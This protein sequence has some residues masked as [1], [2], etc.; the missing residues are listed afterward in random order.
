MTDEHT[1]MKVSLNT[2]LRGV[3][4]ACL[5]HVAQA[6]AVEATWSGYATLGYSVSDSNYTYQRFINKDGSFKADSLVAGQVDLRLS[7]EWSATLQAKLAPAD[8]SDSGY[9]ASAAWAFLAW[10]PSNDWLVRAGKLRI[11]LYLNSES[12]DVG[13]SHDMARLP[14]EMYFISPTNDLTGL[15]VS[16]SFALGEQDISLDAYSGNAK[17]VARLWR[18]DGLPPYVQAGADFRKVEVNLTGLVL[19][20]RS[21]ALTWRVGVLTARTK[22]ASGDHVPVRYPY[23]TVGP[24]LGYWKV[25]NQ[26]PGPPV[27]S[28]PAIRNRA[29]ILGADWQIG[30]GWRVTSEFVRMRQLDTELGSDSKAGYVAVF[31]QLGAW[32]PYIS[33]SRQRSSDELLRWNQRLT[34]DQLP[35]FI[36]GAA[37]SNAAARLA[38]ES[39]FAF[40]QRS[41]SLGLS[42]AYSSTAKIKFEWQRTQVGAASTHFDVPAGQPD[43]QGLRVNSLTANVSVAF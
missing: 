2:I 17:P 23:V 13:V 3:V 22:Q 31:K 12:L 1:M 20:G 6:Q 9:S 25:D 42:Y 34:Q 18:R 30:D 40:D 4:V 24:G 43:A 33:L 10:R 38:G 21:E 39:L 5:L 26:Q 35:A 32:T 11:P 37:Q 7:P 28:A 27:E 8:D 41:T 19:T 29:L 14:Y 36:P 15:Y 16:R